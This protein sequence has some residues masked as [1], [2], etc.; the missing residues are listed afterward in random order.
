M[1]FQGEISPAVK[2][3]ADCEKLMEYANTLTALIH[4]YVISTCG[5]KIKAAM[6]GKNT[7]IEADSYI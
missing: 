1:G 2:F 3:T 5:L 4:A 7:E 6:L